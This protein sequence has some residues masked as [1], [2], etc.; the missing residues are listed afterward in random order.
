MHFA[1]LMG[2]EVRDG[3]AGYFVIRAKY[4]RAQTYVLHLGTLIQ[5]IPF[6]V[7][8]VN[9]RTLRTRFVNNWPCTASNL[10]FGRDISN[11]EAC[12]IKR[13]RKSRVVHP[14]AHVIG[15]NINDRWPSCRLSYC[16]NIT[17]LGRHYQT[18]QEG[19]I[20]LR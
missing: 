2:R 14:Y 8:Q 16:P 18:S 6:N 9:T 5:C 10:M 11:V 13:K 3:R 19:C 17:W 12:I 7:T 20:Q 4:N 1:T 15:K